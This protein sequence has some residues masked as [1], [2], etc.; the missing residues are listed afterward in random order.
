MLAYLCI[1]SNTSGKL[2]G[3][4]TAGSASSDDETAWALSFTN[5]DLDTRSV[6]LAVATHIVES[7]RGKVVGVTHMDAHHI[8]DFSAQMFYEGVD[9]PS[10]VPKWDHTIYYNGRSIRELSTLIPH[11]A[12]VSGDILEIDGHIVDSV[13]SD[14]SLRSSSSTDT[15]IDE[16]EL[17]RNQIKGTER[18]ARDS[19][20]DGVFDAF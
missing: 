11:Y 10:W 5:Y 6:F 16:V 2:S 18:G 19:S 7:R 12:T 8:F 17:Y 20:P 4:S 15:M 13:S 9:L 1:Y 3:F 14:T